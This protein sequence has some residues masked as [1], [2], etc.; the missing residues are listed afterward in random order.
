MKYIVIKETTN[1]VVYRINAN[2]QER[3][4]AIAAE[5]YHWPIEPEE[6]RE[7][8]EGNLEETYRIREETTK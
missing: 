3:A 1:R 5:Q 8:V 6:S 7:A 2:D 4:L